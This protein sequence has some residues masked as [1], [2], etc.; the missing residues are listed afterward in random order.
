MGSGCET[1]NGEGERRRCNGDCACVPRFKQVRSIAAASVPRPAGA[2]EAPVLDFFTLDF[3]EEP[4]ALSHA[5]F[6][7]QCAFTRA[8]ILAI[9]RQYPGA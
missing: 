8:A 3:A 7:A 5:L 9:Q 4:T 2:P 1:K 6:A